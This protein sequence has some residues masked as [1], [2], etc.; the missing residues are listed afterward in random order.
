[1]IF[2]YRTIH[3]K[4]CLLEQ[5]H[6]FCREEGKNPITAS[7]FKTDTEDTKG[8]FK[9]ISCRQTDNAIAKKIDLYNQMIHMI[10]K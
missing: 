4:A 8:T 7:F 1:M 5:Q 3:V 10:L 6:S 2:V 9:V